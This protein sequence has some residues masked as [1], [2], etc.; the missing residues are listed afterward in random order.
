MTYMELPDI[1][2]ILWSRCSTCDYLFY[3]LFFFFRS[4]F[5]HYL[6]HCGMLNGWTT[7]LA[8]RFGRCLPRLGEASVRMSSQFIA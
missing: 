5:A 6:G 8:V 3:L 7:R 4:L 1:F 2:S